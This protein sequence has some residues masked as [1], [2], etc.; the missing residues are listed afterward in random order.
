VKKRNNRALEELLARGVDQS[1][2]D[3]RQAAA[4]APLTSPAYY[5]SLFPREERPAVRRSGVPRRLAVAA[6]LCLALLCGGVAG[7]YHPAA[8]IGIQV[9]PSIELTTNL[10]DRVLEAKALNADGEAI[11]STLELKNVDLDTAVS[12]IIG[13]IVQHDYFVDGTG[14][15][16]ITVSAASASRALSLEER[17]SQDVLSAL[18]ED[19]SVTISTTPA[20]PSPAPPASSQEAVPMPTPVPTQAPVS[21]PAPTPAPTP[22]PQPTPTP[23]P[24]AA[25]EPPP[26]PAPTPRPDPSNG[27]NFWINYLL[28]LDPTLDPGRLQTMSV[29]QLRDLAED[30]EER[31]EDADG[32]RDDDDED[33]DDDQDDNEKDWDDDREDDDKDR[34][35]DRDDDD[36]DRDDGWD[37]QDDDNGKKDRHGRDEDDDDD[38]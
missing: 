6:G 1:L 21:T 19:Q 32:D 4:S 10:L 2:P 16:H 30:L 34:N 38:D 20:S 23:R 26:S 18:P 31:L 24:T 14:T 27:K 22:V 8:R 37:G 12:A 35:D 33:R 36:E 5:E 25:P 3:L 11:L 17:V 29:K 9:N 13:S 28:S 7:Y 15:V